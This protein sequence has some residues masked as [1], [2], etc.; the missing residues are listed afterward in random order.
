MIF[1]TKCLDAKSCDSS[2]A[3]VRWRN[4][5]NLS[6]SL[7]ASAVNASCFLDVFVHTYLIMDD[8]NTEDFINE[9]E[10]Q[11]AVWDSKCDKYSNRLEKKKA[12]DV[13]CEK[14]ITD[15]KTK[16][17]AEKNTAGTTINSLLYYNVIN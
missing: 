12:W 5:N 11:P 10:L 7:F 14:F 4:G 16:K 6:Q 15:F 13:L 3:H 17:A 1:H 8:L 2:A 9:I